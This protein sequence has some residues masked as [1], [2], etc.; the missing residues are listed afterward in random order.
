MAAPI[1]NPACPG[2]Y[3]LPYGVRSGL[4]IAFNGLVKHKNKD[5]NINL[6]SGGNIALHMSF[7]WEKDKI[8]AINAKIDNAWGNEIRHSNP[9][10]HDQAFDL[11]VRVYPGHF[12]VTTNGVLLG[13][14]PHRLPFESIGAISLEG[15]VHINNI[16]F[17]QFH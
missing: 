17:S 9:L 1:L 2:S 15:N 3:A 8:V 12:H 5:F 6:L 13:D 10:H 14:F 4:Q 7:R 11:Q 16:Q